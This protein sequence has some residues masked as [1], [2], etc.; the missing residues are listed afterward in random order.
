M[1]MLVAHFCSV[2]LYDYRFIVAVL[3]LVCGEIV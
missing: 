2:W 1:L 3:T